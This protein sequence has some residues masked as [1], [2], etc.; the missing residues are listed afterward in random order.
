M[1]LF[2]FCVEV[3]SPEA[4]HQIAPTCYLLKNVPLCSLHSIVNAFRFSEGSLVPLK[5]AALPLG[6]FY[7]PTFVPE[8]VAVAAKMPQGGSLHHWLFLSVVLDVKHEPGRA[9]SPTPAQEA[10]SQG[11]GRAADAGRG[12]Q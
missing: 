11:Q 1:P 6:A 4:T 3:K 8:P 9:V 7:R 10:R 5:S 2:Q 12:Q